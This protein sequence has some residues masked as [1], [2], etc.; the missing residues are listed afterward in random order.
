MKKDFSMKEASETSWENVLIGFYHLRDFVSEEAKKII[1]EE[2]LNKFTISF[3]S[4]KTL[5]ENVVMKILQSTNITRHDIGIIYNFLNNFSFC[6]EKI[7]VLAEVLRRCSFIENSLLELI[8]TADVLLK[9]S[10]LDSRALELIASQ[11]SAITQNDVSPPLGTDILSLS[12]IYLEKIENFMTSKSCDFSVKILKLHCFNYLKP[13]KQSTINQ[14][15]IQINQIPQNFKSSLLCVVDKPTLQDITSVAHVRT[16]LLEECANDTNRF[17]KLLSDLIEIDLK[18]MCT[19]NRAIDTVAQITFATFGFLKVKLQ[20]EFSAC[21]HLILREK[22]P[23]FS[24]NFIDGN[25][26]SKEEIMVHVKFLSS[27]FLYCTECENISYIDIL[28]IQV[29]WEWVN[30]TVHQLYFLS[31]NFVEPLKLPFSFDI[32][33]SSLLHFL[34]NC[35]HIL[36]CAYQCSYEILLQKLL[37]IANAKVSLGCALKLVKFVDRF[38]QEGGHFYSTKL[39]PIH[40]KSYIIER[41]LSSLCVCVCYLFIFEIYLLPF[42]CFCFSQLEKFRNEMELI[43]SDKTSKLMIRAK[44]LGM[45]RLRVVFNRLSTTKESQLAA[46]TSLLDHIRCASRESP[47]MLRYVLYKI[48]THIFKDCQ[49]EFFC[50]MDEGHP[51]KLARLV[52]GLCKNI[53]D[54]KILL[55]Q[56]FYATC[57]ILIPSALVEHVV[58]QVDRKEI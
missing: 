6:S 24:P 22:S 41:L 44:Q 23:V 38:G 2:I 26:F 35:G 37:L 47:E 34:E 45:D 30:R 3:E 7:N 16:S 12:T 9:S 28:P 49:E 33:C 36:A 20:R 15:L 46:V 43:E 25:D 53:D 13:L 48:V 17:S 21:Y 10:S 50:E 40:L 19:D 54:L 56:Y 1:E 52:C 27:L 51:Q 58:S 57:P 29:G 39:S 32:I 14:S 18:W 8:T 4:R 31:S 42:F 11:L 5:L 55:K